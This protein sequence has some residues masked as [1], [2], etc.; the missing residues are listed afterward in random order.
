M[1]QQVCHSDGIRNN[2]KL[3]NLRWG[4]QTEN[5]RDKL[6]H[7]TANRGER[8]GKSKLL[9]EDIHRMR[10]MRACGAL[11]TEIASWFSIHKVHAGDIIRGDRWGH[12]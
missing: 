10:D 2:D 5:E 11:L 6:I 4:S 8:H 1:R 9:T 12:A 3:S 7:G